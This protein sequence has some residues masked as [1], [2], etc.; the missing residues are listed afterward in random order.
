VNPSAILES[1]FGTLHDL[2]AVVKMA[3]SLADD[4]ATLAMLLVITQ[5]DAALT[6]VDP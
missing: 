1:P 6:A 3:C 2:D 5:P 4:T